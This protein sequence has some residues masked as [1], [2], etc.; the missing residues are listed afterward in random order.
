MLES[1][2][3]ESAAQIQ[4]EK[5]KH[6][7][8]KMPPTSHTLMDLIITLS[9]YL[10]RSSF[11]PLFTIAALVI[12]RDDDAQLQKKA[13]KLIPRLAESEQGRQALEDRSPELQKLLLDAAEKASA[14]SR[15]DRLVAISGL[16]PSLPASDLSFIPC[17][18]SEVVIAAKEVNEKARTAAFDLLVQ[19]GEK[20]AAGGTIVSANVPHLGPS[21]PNMNASLEEFFTMVSAGLVGTTP[22][23][24][25]A[26]ITAL[27]RLFFQFH[28]QLSEAVV[29]DLVQTM[30]LFLTSKNREMVRSVLGFVKVCILSLPTEM[31][32]PRLETLIPNLMV[33]SHEHKAHFRAKVKHII[34]R[35]VRRFGVEIV[36]KYC[37][38]EDKKLITNIRKTRDRKKRKKADG[39]NEDEEDKPE[40]KG[41]F[42]SEF[43]R[44][45]YSSDEESGSDDEEERELG[46][47][48]GKKKS[49][50]Y[51]VEDD[52]EPLDLLSR[53]ALGNIS[54]TKP[55]PRAKQQPQKR[56]AKVDLDGKLIL[57]DSSDEEDDDGDIEMDGTDLTSGINAYVD[58]IRGAD[59][60]RRGAKG[61]LKFKNSRAGK[62]DDGDDDEMDVDDVKEVG[63]KIKG[64]LKE[65]NGN[66]GGFRGR[67]GFKANRR[68]LGVQKGH[69][70]RVDKRGGGKFRGRR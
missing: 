7:K 28:D 36:E 41:Q 37:P 69:G 55:L 54:S 25:S 20:M 63:K 49:Q 39:D 11:P 60:A 45:V 35:L 57:K 9:I 10:P 15:R 40:R 29:V 43:D 50:T 46:A 64:Q 56:K 3:A 38:E 66:R 32:K 53:N 14:P 19:M 44:A 6:P 62:R 18:L 13:Y 17:I 26:S 59:V 51:I 58:A 4:A 31:V 22:H 8:D 27:S 2:L 48:R 12:N 33:W 23:M 42:E 24:V 16:I 5:Q 65:S 30:D 1:S 52:D 61:K 34:E 70:G 21:I 68:G 67:G 47:K